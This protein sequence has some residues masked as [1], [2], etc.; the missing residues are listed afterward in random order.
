MRRNGAVHLC[1]IPFFLIKKIAVFLDDKLQY[2]LV[3]E[4][5]CKA[6]EDNIKILI[7]GKNVSK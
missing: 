2:I 6:S 3:F 5:R 1:N 7:I 4:C